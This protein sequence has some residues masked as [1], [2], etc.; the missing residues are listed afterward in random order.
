L[1]RGASQVRSL[2][3]TPSG[4][5]AQLEEPP[6]LNRCG[7]GSTPAGA[8]GIRKGCHRR[9]IPSRY[10]GA[11]RRRL[12][13]VGLR[14]LEG[15]TPSPS[16]LSW[17]HGRVADGNAL[18]MRR[19]VGHARRFESCCL[20]S[21]SGVVESARR[22]AVTREAQVR[23]LLPELSRPRGRWVM[24]PS[25]QLGRAGSSPAGGAV[26]LW[27]SGP[28]RRSWAP[29]IAGSTPAG[30]TC[31]DGACRRRPEGGGGFAAGTV[32]NTAR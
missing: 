14:G 17:R 25:S 4:F 6:T 3:V 11:G 13:A 9:G 18:L 20:R 21:R 31:R 32:R 7:A 1:K 22:A 30:Q 24:T 28:P 10:G 15:S 26:W 5:V 16:A 23:A 27:G 2:P 8:I 12:P 19:R 29:E